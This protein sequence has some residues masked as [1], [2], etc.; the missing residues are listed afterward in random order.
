MNAG[1]VGRLMNY[2]HICATICANGQ[3][4][5]IAARTP[6]TMRLMNVHRNNDEER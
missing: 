4:S 5:R 3:R 2:R 1:A 6:T